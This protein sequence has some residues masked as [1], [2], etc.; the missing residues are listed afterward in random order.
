[1]HTVI[2]FAI[3]SSLAKEV[4]DELIT[5]G[6]FT[7]AWLG[8][9]IH[10]L[11]DDAD[12]RDLIKA[13]QDGVV[14]SKIRPDGPA[15]KSELKPVDVITAVDGKAVSTA[16]QLRAEIRRKRIGEAVT[17]DV[18]RKGKTIQIKVSPG[19][20]VEPATL[21]DAKRSPAAENDPA[22]LG[23]TVH[24]LTHELASQFGV[25][26][27][28]GVLVVAIER[29]SIAANKGIKPGDIITSINQQSV[30]N[31]KQFRETLKRA[32]LKKGI[33]VNLLSGDT[34]RFEI[35]KEGAE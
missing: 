33:I 24:A 10:A 31:P 34:A 18:F 32:D 30:P 29:G 26:F 25:D 14:I 12:F 2:G 35:L 21:A 28:E 4:S 5:A 16:Q 8:I 19:E 20:W 1:L 27:T 3:P 9:E 6:K 22:G 7:R 17:L 13:P 15:A 23:M 11:R